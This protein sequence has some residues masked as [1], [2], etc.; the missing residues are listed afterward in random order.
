MR[1]RR[2]RRKKQRRKEGGGGEQQSQITP[3]ISGDVPYDTTLLNC[4]YNTC[5][6]LQGGESISSLTQA[7]REREK[8]R[9]KE[10]KRE[11]VRAA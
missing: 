1:T 4:D 9:K 5:N 11:R 6:Q 2:R 3:C 10:R 8:E 7:E